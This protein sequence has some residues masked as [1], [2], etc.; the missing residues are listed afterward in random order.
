MTHVSGDKIGRFMVAIGAIIE[1]EQTGNIL[2][3]KRASEFHTGT[4]EPVYGRIDQYE[5]LEEGLRRE[6]KEEVGI[7][8]LEIK[9]LVRVWHIFRGERIAHQEVYGFTFHCVV[10]DTDV[11]ISDEHS[12]FEWVPKDKVV[13]RITAAGIRKDMEFFLENIS[14]PKIAVSNVQGDNR[15]IF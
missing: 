9:R 5:E 1:H 15:Y 6:V 14:D 10:K 7:T 2:L 8:D 3:I 11:T 4:W 12:A 13:E